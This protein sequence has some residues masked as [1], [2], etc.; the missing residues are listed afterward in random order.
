[1]VE[2]ETFVAKIEADGVVFVFWIVME[3]GEIFLLLLVAVRKEQEE[4]E[5]EE[6]ASVG[7]L[8]KFDLWEWPSLWHWLVPG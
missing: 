5:L 8:L 7:K 4:Q 1:M 2:I 6:L 3:Q